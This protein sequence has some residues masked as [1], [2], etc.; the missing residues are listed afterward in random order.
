MIHTIG[1]PPTIPT[2]TIPTTT[3]P[4]T[5]IP[6]STIPAPTIPILAIPASTIPVPTIPIFTIPTPTMYPPTMHPPTI[7]HP[8]ILSPTISPIFVNP[9][10]SPLASALINP[11]SAP[12]A[13]IIIP[14]KPTGTDVL[15]SKVLLAAET[16]IQKRTAE[17]EASMSTLIEQ[18]AKKQKTE[19]LSKQYKSLYTWLKD[20][21]A[22]IKSLQEQEN[23]STVES[24]TTKQ[25]EHVLD[26]GLE[27]V[28]NPRSVGKRV[29]K[30]Q[31]SFE[32]LVKYKE[33]Y[34]SCDT[35]RSI[36][37]MIGEEKN[38]RNRL[39]SWVRSTT[40][41]LTLFEKDPRASTLDPD[42][43]K[44]LKNIGFVKHVRQDGNKLPPRGRKSWDENFNDLQAF[45]EE[46]SHTNVPHLPKSS[47]RNWVVL[48]R[49]MYVR[50]KE[51]RKSDLN[52]ERVTKLLQLGF[53]LQ[54]SS[55]LT[56]DE[57]AA[58]WLEFKTKHGREPLRKKED[59][60]EK[61]ESLGAWVAKMRGKY[62]LL[63]G[64]EKTNLTHE[65]VDKLIARGFKWETGFKKP[66]VL[67]PR[68]SWEERFAELCAYKNEN[69]HVNVPQLY[70]Q[71]GHWVHRQRQNYRALKLGYR[72]SLSDEKLAKLKDVGF[73]FLTR[74]SPRTS[75]D[76]PTKTE[77]GVESEEYTASEEDADTDTDTDTNTNHDECNDSEH[78]DQSH[79]VIQKC[80]EQDAR[81]HP[82]IVCN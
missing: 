21:R 72:N 24:E 51:G 37:N 76:E 70:P 28:R 64:G 8:T 4:T 40:D 63:K 20:D 44:Q 6:A 53:V 82:G 78:L 12:L 56:F 3:I 41:Q 47:L 14:P 33:K 11:K 77:A 39:K 58:E 38:E 50:L 49:D 75:K 23:R 22:K 80:Y 27:A 42:R 66:T 2:P 69:G 18:P 34:G 71:L 9:M 48:Q 32:M 35:Q 46:N 15:D 5:T 26:L 52:G 17:E 81:R 1:Q 68:K 54:P 55:R 7:I 73:V 10:G 60:S 36:E 45:K 79:E 62:V 30:W 61:E 43:V 19:S 67:G 59:T 16:V 29:V 65:Q 13:P 31:R 25:V 57:R 74:K